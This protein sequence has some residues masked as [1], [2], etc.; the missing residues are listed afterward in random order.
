MERLKPSE[1]RKRILD[2]HQTL[3]TLLDALEKG[4]ARLKSG[5]TGLSEELKARAQELHESL[6]RH[7]ADEEALLLP[8]LEEADGFG[9]A[10][11]AAL[12]EEH[13]EQ[14]GALAEITDAIAHSTEPQVLATRL[15]ALIAR[16][17]QDMEEEEATHL[18]PTVLKDDIITAGFIG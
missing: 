6:C 18:S 13:V 7:I 5:E 8:E 9:P 17:R 2:Q 16:I 11:V 4:V 15:D 10:R 3:R 1:I 14:R 12:R